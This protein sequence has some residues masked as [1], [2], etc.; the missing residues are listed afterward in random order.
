MCTVS[1]SRCSQSRSPASFGLYSGAIAQ[2]TPLAL[3]VLSH[4]TAIQHYSHFVEETGCPSK[5]AEDCLRKISWQAAV[6]AEIKAQQKVYLNDF[7]SAFMPYGPTVDG[8]ELTAAPIDLVN[9]G[10]VNKVPLIIGESP[11]HVRNALFQR[12]LFD[13]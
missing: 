11:W 7:L 9:Q 8:I 10:K 5:G 12:P 13:S 4:E 1:F 3:P 6:A 2:S